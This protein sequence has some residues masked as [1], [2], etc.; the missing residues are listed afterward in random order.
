[1][2][3]PLAL[4]VAGRFAIFG[5]LYGLLW[6][7][8]LGGLLGALIAIAV[9][10]PLSYV[11]LRRQRENLTTAMLARAQRRSAERQRLRSRLDE[12]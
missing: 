11:V 5:A 2:I 6:A 3:I 10:V 8:G 1:M 9:S 12:Q 7:V 4:Y